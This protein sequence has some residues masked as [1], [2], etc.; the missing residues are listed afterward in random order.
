MKIEMK[1][2]NQKLLNKVDLIGK[3]W[4]FAIY[5]KIPSKYVDKEWVMFEGK[6]IT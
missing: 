5:N 6:K 3:T 4:K 1:P 2:W